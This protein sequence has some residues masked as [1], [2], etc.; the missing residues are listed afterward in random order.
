MSFKVQ[1]NAGGQC[2]TDRHCPTKTLSARGDMGS[3]QLHVPAINFI[4]RH[5]LWLTQEPLCRFL[6]FGVFHARIPQSEHGRLFYSIGLS[7]RSISELGAELRVGNLWIGLNWAVF[8]TF[9]FM[10]HGYSDRYIVEDSPTSLSSLVV[11]VRDSVPNRS[12]DGSISCLVWFPLWLR[13]GA[14][15]PVEGT[16]LGDCWPSGLPNSHL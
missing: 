12:D 2:T 13:Q 14:M 4:C 1:F 9:D 10:V 8:T 7:F 16:R 6:L 11:H 15:D 5:G 3:D